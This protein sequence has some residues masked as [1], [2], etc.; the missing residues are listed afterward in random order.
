MPFISENLWQ[1]ISGFNFTDDN[2]SVHLESW[3]VVSKAESKE[4]SVLD[5]MALVKKAVELGLAKRDEAGIKIRQ[6]LNLATIKSNISLDEAY[7]SLILDELNVKSLNWKLEGEE[8]SVDLDLVITPELKQE[9]LRRELV[10]SINMIR[11][12]A[13][14]SLGDKALVYVSADNK[15]LKNVIKLTKSSLL[16]DTLSDDIIEG[17]GA[18]LVKI[19][20]INGGDVKLSLIKNN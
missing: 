10:R 16:K 2:R 18:G 20:K 4:Q 5:N 11:K 17:E 12:D 1:K 14:L 3:P 13:G 15:E 7:Y 6:M 9:G 19:V 8:M